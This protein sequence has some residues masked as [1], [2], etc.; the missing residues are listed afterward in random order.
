MIV[1][2]IIISI[3]MIIIIG[4]GLVM[5]MALTVIVLIVE[6]CGGVFARRLGSRRNP[7]KGSRSGVRLKKRT[8]GTPLSPTFH[9]QPLRPVFAKHGRYR[10][11]HRAITVY[12]FRGGGG[13]GGRFANMPPESRSCTEGRKRYSAD[14]GEHT[15]FSVNDIQA[16]SFCHP[17]F[18]TS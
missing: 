4:G 2:I 6:R 1:I 15:S 5:V 16:R 17:T 3:I 13:E 10:A 14:P 11:G 9:R 12:L 18:Q 7:F 8:V